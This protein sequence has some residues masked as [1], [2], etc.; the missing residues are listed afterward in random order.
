MFEF[1]KMLRVFRDE[2]QQA[3]FERDGYIILPFYNA[4]EIAAIQAP[5]STG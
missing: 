5:A 2:D 4:E 3:Q 1:P